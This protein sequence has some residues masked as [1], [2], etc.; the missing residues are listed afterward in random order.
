[1]ELRSTIKFALLGNLIAF[2]IIYAIES[3]T[4]FFGIKYPSDY[5]FF[6]LML[7]WGSAAL[8][9]M[10]PPGKVAGLEV[11]PD[12]KNEKASEEENTH[13]ERFD[14]NTWTCIKLLVSGS[15]ALTYCIVNQLIN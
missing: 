9:Y 7:L 2:A 11:E 6:V 4:Q 14:A 12:S 15:P 13:S 1:M 10:Y 8:L 5:A 3:T